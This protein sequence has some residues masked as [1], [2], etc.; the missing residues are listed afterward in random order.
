VAIAVIVPIAPKLSEVTSAD[1]GSFV[2]GKYESAKANVVATKHFAAGSGATAM[3]VVRRTDRA[4]LTTADRTRIEKF[5]R[6][7]KGAAVQRVTAVATG[8]QQLS[9]NKRAQLVSV[10]FEGVADEKPVQN[11]IKTLRLKARASLAGSDLST[12]LT[13]E[14]AIQTDGMDSAQ[15]AMKI[16]SIA[17]IALIIILLGAVFRGPLTALMPVI[18]IGG[19]YA[20]TTALLASVAKIVGFTLSDNL[21]TLLVVV[22]FGIGT[23]Y[24]LF[25][26]FRYRE[27]LR[28][29][30]D[31]KTAIT[32]AIARV[33]QAIT[34]SAL[35]VVSA[36]LAL[37]LSS[38]GSMRNMAPGFLIAISLMLLAALTLIPALLTLLGTHAF[39]PSK[40]WKK[41]PDAKMTRQTGE[42]IGR[43]PRRMALIISPFLIALAAGA[44]FFNAD[45]NISNQ[46]PSNTESAKGFTVLKQSFPAGALNPTQVYVVGAKATDKAELSRV[47]KR[48]SAVKGVAKV[49]PAQPSKDGQ[50]AVISVE[51]K[52]SPYDNS[53]LDLV[54]GPLRRAAHAGEKSGTVLVGGQTMAFAD[55]RSA[56]NR[57]YSVVFPVAALMIAL[58]LGI[59]LRSLIAPILLLIAVVLGFAAT[60]GASVGVFQVIEGNPGVS[61]FLPLMVYLFVIAMGTDYNILMMTRL[62]EEAREGNNPRKSAELAVE[63]AA[64]TVIAAG[65]ILAGTFAS[66]MLGG[67]GLLSQMGFTIA[68]GIAIVSFVM[69]ALL[70]PSIAALLGHMIWW[71]GHSDELAGAQ[72][73]PALKPQPLPEDSA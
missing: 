73:L 40:G 35:V 41:E 4:K 26:L 56:L 2:P 7:L 22:L 16:V 8:D 36:F 30:D 42:F 18:A 25:L 3:F 13:G 1:Q 53:A 46:L 58:I 27:R 66:L 34:S 52:T 19:I 28:A 48:L 57:D 51:L 17:T 29:G 20:L 38:L 39:W 5:V 31:Y 24:V 69:A 10:S 72:P 54:A 6:D 50:A 62:R 15:S 44:L 49:A 21:T 32:F 71:P 45:Y 67:I 33:G 65:T 61:F 11:A 43:H 60:L 37:L 9:P 70:I 59:V 68:V 23:D 47:A 64:P 12:L 14:A 63:H 55:V